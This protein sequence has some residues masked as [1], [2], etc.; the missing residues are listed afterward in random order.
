M[1]GSRRIIN[2][3]FSHDDH[4]QSSTPSSTGKEFS[5]TETSAVASSHAHDMTF[6]QREP[7]HSSRLF[8]A[9][10]MQQRDHAPDH[11]EVMDSARG[12]QYTYSTIDRVLPQL[13]V[14]QSY[15]AQR[16]QQTGPFLDMAST[17]WQRPEVHR[18]GYSY[19]SGNENAAAEPS[20]WASS[21]AIQQPGPREWTEQNT[22]RQCATLGLHSEQLPAPCYPPSS[23]SGD[24][25]GSRQF[26]PHYSF[27]TNQIPNRSFLGRDER[28]RPNDPGPHAHTAVS[29]TAA[30]PTP[31]GPALTSAP[32]AVLSSRP[33]GGTPRHTPDRH[34]SQL[35]AAERLPGFGQPSLPSIAPRADA[36]VSTFLPSWRPPALAER[37]LTRTYVLQDACRWPM[38]VQTSNS[39]E[40]RYEG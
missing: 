32:Y 9:S 2:P 10:W 29:R 27:S 8:G 33:L 7:A 12:A 14:A 16:H 19:P 6:P 38:Y 13:Q 30:W 22:A 11:I 3:S 40:A 36:E 26:E 37:P 24:D 35:A 18:L 5:R 4:Q 31:E 34:P 1:A 39:N 25:E 15:L 21:Q 20:D 28:E 17:T 23:I